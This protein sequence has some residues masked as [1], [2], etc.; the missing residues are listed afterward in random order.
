M[1]L[2][3][4]AHVKLT[5]EEYQQDGL[6]KGVKGVIVDVYENEAYEVDFSDEFGITLACIAVKQY[7]VEL[8]EHLES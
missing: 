2:P 3:I 1:P 5:S 4:F 6:P 8:V 7:D